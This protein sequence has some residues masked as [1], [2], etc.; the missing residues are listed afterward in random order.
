MES[1]PKL[2][3]LSLILLTKCAKMFEG[4]PYLKRPSA[5][6][7][8]CDCNIPSNDW[9]N[10]GVYIIPTLKGHHNGLVI[11]V[12]C[13]DVSIVFVKQ[14]S[15]ILWLRRSWPAPIQLLHYQN[16]ASAAALSWHWQCV[17]WTCDSL[18]M[19]GLKLKHVSKRV[20]G[21]TL[22]FGMMTS[23]NRN[24]FTLLALCAGISS[25]TGE[26]PS[27]RKV[28]RSFDVFFDMR[29]N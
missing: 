26:F 21:I 3:K 22:Q 12:H 5:S 6:H 11:Y 28:T 24:I 19:V 23:S 29:L 15:F 25:V 13:E 17:Y 10:Y 1:K 8:L 20:P 18:S 7:S 27:Q 2:D 14:I 9:D 4:L 16:L